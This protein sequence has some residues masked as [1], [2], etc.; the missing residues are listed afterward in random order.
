MNTSFL[1]H[2]FLTE[3]SPKSRGFKFIMIIIDI[4]LLIK[5]EI[6]MIIIDIILLMKSEIIMIII[7]IILL[8]KSEIM[9]GRRFDDLLSRVAAVERAVSAQQCKI[10]W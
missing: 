2:V 7:A 6:F 3:E 9:R 5:S 1:L 8:I 4:I 10:N